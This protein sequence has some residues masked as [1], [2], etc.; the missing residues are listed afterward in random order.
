MKTFFLDQFL[1]SHIHFNHQSHLTLT[2]HG[3]HED[4]S[5]SFHLYLNWN[6]FNLLLNTLS[7]QKHFLKQMISGT[8][9]QKVIHTIKNS[10]KIDSCWLVIKIIEFCDNKAVADKE[11]CVEN[12]GFIPA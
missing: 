7:D 10:V 3:A 8:L 6:E 12:Y 2:C 1:I 5:F 11:Y 9:L 4:Q